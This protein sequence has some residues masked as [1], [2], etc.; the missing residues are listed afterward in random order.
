MPMA[1]KDD[2]MMTYHEGLTTE[3]S[4]EPF[5]TCLPRSSGKLKSLQLHYRSGYAINTLMDANF[6]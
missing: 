4:H 1:T 3:K 2:R 6:L 5:I